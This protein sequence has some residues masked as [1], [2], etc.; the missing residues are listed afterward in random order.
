MKRIDELVELLNKYNYEYYSNDAP[1]VSDNE[2]DSLLYELIELEKQ[3][4]SLIREDSPT[5]KVGS[6]VLSNFEKVKH[7]IP[8]FSLGNVFNDSELKDFHN[9]IKKVIKKPQYVCELKIDGLSVSLEY[10]EGILFRAST[11]GDGISGENITHNVKTIKSIPI[12]LNKCVNI[13]VRGEIFMPKSSLEKLNKEREKEDLPLFQNCRNA[14]AGSIRQLDSKVCSKRNLDA[15]LYHLPTNDLK[16]HYE[17]LEYFKTLGLKVNPNIEI[18]DDIK[19]VINYIKKWTKKRDTLSYDIDGI[20]IK[21]NSI[22]DQEKLGYTAKTPKWA[23]A[24]KFPALEAET[25]LTDII[26][27]VG[28]SGSI[29]PNAVLNPVKIAGSTISRATLHNENFVKEKNLLIGD[30]I[31]LR[32]AG[33]VIPEV[34]RPN[35]QRRTGKE[36]PFKM[37]TSCPI[38]NEPLI[39]KNNSVDYFCTNDLCP[40]RNIEALIHFTSRDAMNIEG[41]GEKILEDFYNEKIITTFSN[42]YTLYNKKDKLMLLEGFGQKSITKLLKN[43]EKSK[44]SSL[45]RL[46]YALGIEGIGVKNAK[47]LCK[48]FHTIDDFINATYEDYEEI[49]TIGKVLASSL[50][51]YFLD[52]NNIKIINELKSLGVNMISNIKL[53][54]KETPVSNKTVVI[55]GTFDISRTNIKNKLEALG[56][57]ISESVS[58]ST[59]I[60]LV[61]DNPG[62]K[63]EKA[64]KL[65]IE[66][67]SKD[68]LNDLLNL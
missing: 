47:T 37:I 65:N 63:Y 4:P 44:A 18:C 32:K 26:F 54:N 14:A 42:I 68:K 36:L 25:E 66:I 52:E 67:C 49:K 31:Y 28:R 17:S 24:Y 22:Q 30:Y 41:L 3:N 38:C 57:N 43:I 16:T 45:E 20:V 53:S 1:T 13:T 60:V 15:F 48:K 58:A 51:S 64:L 10:K 34:L 23:I 2:Y 5:Q 27:T 55:T 35:I 62:S 8:M 29:T 6:K 39:K 12:K 56:A 21:V 40:K 9:R 33:D 46:I 59:D 50:V 61:G 11:R 19:S 7:E